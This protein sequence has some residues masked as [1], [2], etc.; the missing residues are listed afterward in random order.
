MRTLYPWLVAAL[1]AISMTLPPWAAFPLETT[2]AGERCEQGVMAP[3]QQGIGEN[4]LSATVTGIDRKHG[5]L[6]LATEAGRVQVVL[7]ADT[8]LDLHVGDRVTL[9]TTD[10]VPSQNLLQDSIRT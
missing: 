1:L 9:C 7:P 8:L 10:E 2:A 6:E 4:R 3:V 5:V